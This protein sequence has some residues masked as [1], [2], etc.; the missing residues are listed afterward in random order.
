MTQPSGKQ[1][2][3][4]TKQT[5]SH[6]MLG[7]ATSTTPPELS[8]SLSNSTVWPGTVLLPCH[9]PHSRDSQPAPTLTPDPVL[10]LPY[11][12]LITDPLQ[13]HLCFLILPKTL[14][15]D[16]PALTFGLY[17]DSSLNIDLAYLWTV[18]TQ[19]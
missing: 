15:S 1:Q 10:S 6:M 17:L 9:A 16:Y 8:I 12:N 11:S 4:I 3:P 14:D 5:L 2:Q 19:L 18:T 13:P 7:S